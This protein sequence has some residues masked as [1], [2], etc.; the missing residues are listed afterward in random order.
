[1]VKTQTRFRAIGSTATGRAL[2]NSVGNNKNKFLRWIFFVCIL[3]SV[4]AIMMYEGWVVG[5]TDNDNLLYGT[6]HPAQKEWSVEKESLRKVSAATTKTFAPCPKEYCKLVWF[7]LRPEHKLYEPIYRAFHSR[8]YSRT[9]DITRA[10]Y[11]WTDQPKSSRDFYMALQPWQRY[12]N[13]PNTNQWDDKDKMADTMNKYY[14]QRG[15]QPLHSF[16]ESY[17]LHLPDGLEAFRI[18]LL[19]ENGGMDVPWVLKK[20]TV[21]QGKGV[22][23]LPPQS[24][25][26][27][28]IVKIIEEEV[29]PSDG[30]NK[31]RLVAQK[32]ICDEMTYKGRKFDVRVFWAVASVDPLV[33]LYHT[34]QNYVRIGH[35]LY[36]ESKLGNSTTKDI[37]T[38]HTFG[39]SETKATWDEFR[40]LIESHVYGSESKFRDRF[41]RDNARSLETIEAILSDPFFHVQNQMKTVIGHLVN[42]YQN[43]TFHGR[44]MATEN[45]FASH[46]ADMIIDNNLDV[47]IIEGTDGPGK[48]EDYDF[49]IKM[50]DELVGSLVDVVEEVTSRQKE[51]MRLDVSEMKKKGVLGGYEVVYNDGWFMDYRYQRLPKMPCLGA[52]SSD[53]ARS[54]YETMHSN[55]LIS[56]RKIVPARFTA[57][58]KKYN[59]SNDDM[60]FWMNSRT[61]RRY[62]PVARSLRH[63]GWTPVDDPEN[64][65]LIYHYEEYKDTLQPWQWLNQFPSQFSF[66]D[67]DHQRYLDYNETGQVCQPIQHG[68]RRVE[69]IVYWLVFSIDPLIVL[70]HD[71]FVYF[72]YS[73]DDENEFLDLPKRNGKKEKIWNGSWAALEYYLNLNRANTMGSGNSAE[74]K[75]AASIS[76]DPISHVKNQ[77]KASM[78]NLA[79]GFSIHA[80]GQNQE[81]KRL[82]LASVVNLAKGLPRPEM[83]QNLEVGNFSSFAIFCAHF[84]VDQNLNIFALDAQH[85]YVRGEDHAEIVSLHDELYG[86]AF[87]LLKYLNSTSKEVTSELD[88]LNDEMLGNYEWLIKPD[89]ADPKSEPWNFRYD[90]KYKARECVELM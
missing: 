90:W 79:K 26:L 74:A 34:E 78:V 3:Y 49:R 8:G 69:I 57:L 61:S 10:H 17:L 77:M 31:Y 13:F 88:Q 33:V 19:E 48:D 23:V 52:S 7:R 75:A 83:E 16:P 66:F 35:A 1:M 65:Q 67:G 70:Y 2:L 81:R 14:A 25:E 21:N 51:G 18:R 50:H 44:D 56:T 76:L 60:T 55:A 29:K 59:S 73:R 30:S 82:P 41:S 36:D 46:A 24:K 6:I 63:N 45:G 72:E 15:I 28:G 80:M 58:P 11:L 54:K 89:I 38:T 32:Y 37:L 9:E 20:P 47:Y 4:V 64:A 85:S 53:S 68:N 71:G 5:Q 84:Q 42:A 86:S 43:I 87:R 39:A 27:K 12:N 40:E 62:E 22:A